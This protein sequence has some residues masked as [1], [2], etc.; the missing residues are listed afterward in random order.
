MGQESSLS[1][2][3]VTYVSYISAGKRSFPVAGRS[4][5]G[6]RFRIGHKHNVLCYMTLICLH[7]FWQ[8]ILLNLCR[9]IDI[10]TS[11]LPDSFPDEEAVQQVYLGAH[12]E[13]RS[14]ERTDS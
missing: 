4:L 13:L 10:A 7:N 12:L 14:Q 9:L 8:T 3:L 5:W 2:M 1:F 11:R 6:V